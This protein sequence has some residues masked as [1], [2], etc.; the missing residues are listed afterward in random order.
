MID[1]EGGFRKFCSAYHDFGVHI[2]KDGSIRAR[3]WAP[4]A[5]GL[6]LRG[7]FNNWNQKSH[8]FKNVGFGTVTTLADID[9][10]GPN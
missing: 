6:Y 3:E 9:D 8:P 5:K 7:D 10:N 1:A 2:E 4:G